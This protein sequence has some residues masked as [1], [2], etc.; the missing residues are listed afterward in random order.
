VG[1]RALLGWLGSHGEVVV[2]AGVEGTGS[3]GAGLARHLQREGV[4][5]VE[6]DRTRSHDPDAE[7]TQ[8]AITSFWER[9]LVAA[10][11]LSLSA[12]SSLRAGTS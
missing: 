3:Y 9:L 10:F 11:G 5:V 12:L 1:Y 6:V 7:P 2:V 4:A 8:D